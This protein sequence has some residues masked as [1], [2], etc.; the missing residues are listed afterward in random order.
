MDSNNNSSNSKDTK[1]DGN[2]ELLQSA[3]TFLNDDSVKDAPLTKK[4]EF[5]QTK[6]LNQQEIE[7][8]ISEA[9]KPENQNS[10]HN[11]KSSNDVLTTAKD[12]RTNNVD[13]TNYIYETL[14][15]PLPQRDW[16]DYFVMATVTAGLVYG[17]LEVTKRY[18]IPNILPESKS[19][20]EQDKD[21]IKS[22][23]DKIDQVLNAIEVEH[24]EFKEQEQ[25]K[26]DELDTTVEQLET[27]LEESRRSREQMDDD[28]RLLKLEMA[29][30]QSS[31]DKF[32][33]NNNGGKELDS[34]NQELVSLKNL[35]KNSN[36]FKQPPKNNTT[37]V[38]SNGH[39]EIS[40]YDI[41]TD[42]TNDSHPATEGVPGIESI[43][44]A[45][46]LLAKFSKKAQN[47]SSASNSESNVSDNDNEADVPAWKASR[48]KTILSMQN[49]SNSSKQNSNSEI[50]EWQRMLQGDSD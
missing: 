39:G 29:T 8:A 43:P 41:G 22:Q 38:V 25:K 30:L 47:E 11:P 46:E 35:I 36:I 9:K 37:D 3:I 42:Y 34:I 14:P 1:L 21:E 44:I 40:S 17:V 5:L 27:L 24:K 4:I 19:K 33:T 7:F 2:S 32:I 23:F 12:I 6:G 31:L 49:S 10:I 50:P 28:F 18:V 16:K 26:L 13:E 45:S 48:E 20:L 15:P